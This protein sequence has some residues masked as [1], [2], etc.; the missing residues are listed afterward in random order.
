[1][2]RIEALVREP[3]HIGSTSVTVGAA[4]GV[5]VS[6]RGYESAEAMLHDADSA[7]YRAKRLQRAHRSTA[8]DRR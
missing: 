3:H 1:V 6:S 5:A 7:M 2:E 4:I 8:L